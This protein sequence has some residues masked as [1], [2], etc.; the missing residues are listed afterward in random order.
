[1]TEQ[2]DPNA[3]PWFSSLRLI[4]HDAR[5]DFA[6]IQQYLQ[7]VG[8][9]ID[10]RF[11]A[12]IEDVEARLDP[13][14]HD[15]GDVYWEA[16]KAFGANPLEIHAHTG[17]MLVSRGVA[18]S[19]IV[20][21]SI[22]MA[23]FVDAEPLVYR[24]NHSWSRKMANLFY[25]TCLARPV[26]IADGA[27]A[28]ITQLRDLYAHGYG[29]PH[30]KEEAEKLAAALHPHLGPAEL[31]PEEDAL[32]FTEAPYAFGRYSDYSPASGFKQDVFVPVVAELSPVAARRLLLLIEER[33]E[34]ALLAAS[35]GLKNPLDE[36]T[37][38]FVRFWV[39]EEAER[40]A[41]KE[42]R[43]HRAAEKARRQEAR[44]EERA[45]RRR[46]DR[47]NGLARQAEIRRE[48]ARDG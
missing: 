6:S 4:A 16:E 45:E 10:K 43:E 34:A 42:A 26:S 15:M 41:Q 36:A 29:R 31:T 48:A 8:P 1:M 3:G 22:P 39:Q 20:F 13:E 23:L 46:L 28:P 32:G 33:V 25:Q 2:D 19:E 17:L 18:L 40:K 9:E 14:F 38:K 44:R 35:W 21:A 27:M 37:S 47:R 30:R 12:V 24:G 7:V 11:D 5:R